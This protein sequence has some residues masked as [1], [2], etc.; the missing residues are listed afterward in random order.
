MP[1]T[2]DRGCVTRTENVAHALTTRRLEL[3]RIDAASRLGRAYVELLRVQD[4]LSAHNR[5]D[6]VRH[7]RPGRSGSVALFTTRCS[8]PVMRAGT[9][10]SVS[11]RIR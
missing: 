6:E 1:S 4:V 8:V 2:S 10:F 9:G 3:P 5:W 7:A 11:R